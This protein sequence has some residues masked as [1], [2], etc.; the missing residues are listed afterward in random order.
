[1]HRSLIET[2]LGAAVIA[3]A[4][5]FLVFGYTETNEVRFGGYPIKAKF[6]RVDGVK[7]GDEVRMFG[8]RVGSVAKLDLDPED[9]LVQMTMNINHGVQLHSDAFAAINTAGLFSGKFI[10]LDPGGGEDEI[11]KPGDAIA[12]V[13]DSVILDELVEKIVSFAKSS[14]VPVKKESGASSGAT[15]QE[16]TP[17]SPPKK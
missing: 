11:L 5:L 15:P 14:R 10:A 7:I 8:V 3:V 2:L 13:Q 4:I 9:F 1:M 6:S 12:F 16:A 17:S